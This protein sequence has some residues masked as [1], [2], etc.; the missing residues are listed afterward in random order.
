MNTVEGIYRYP[1]KGLSGENMTSVVLNAGEVIPGDRE[2]AFARAGV[3]FD[4]DK[5]E[6]LQKTNFLA[7]VQDEKLAGF[8]TRFDPASKMLS[9]F[10]NSKLIMETDLANPADCMEAVKFFREYL[11]M[12]TDKSPHIVRAT[13]G[14]IG[15][16]F[17][18]V[19]FKAISLINLSSI[20]DFGGK[21]D[22]DINPLRFRG[23]I[24][25]EGDV[26]WVEFDWID[27]EIRIGNV[28]MRAVKRTERCAATTVN[29]ATAERDINILKELRRNYGHMDLGIYAEVLEGGKIKC[30]DEV[31]LI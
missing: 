15:H 11:D 20:R 6:Y 5:P 7:L 2:Y 8:E 18:D 24:N 19:P 27:R 12:P 25:F 23:N 13:G 28:I 10:Q 30:G 17:S 16:S 29:P 26:P 1:I 22:A 3:Q 9:I 31:Q 21:I 4:P 14:T